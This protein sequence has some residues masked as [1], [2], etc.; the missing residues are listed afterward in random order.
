MQILAAYTF[1]FFNFKFVISNVWS[2][3]EVVIAY[4]NSK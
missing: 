1:I 4:M 3:I 2:Y